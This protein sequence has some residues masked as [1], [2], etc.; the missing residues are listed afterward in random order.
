MFFVAPAQ[1]VEFRK[2][3]KKIMSQVQAVKFRKDTEDTDG[4]IVAQAQSYTDL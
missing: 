2:D 4:R 1:A 3:V